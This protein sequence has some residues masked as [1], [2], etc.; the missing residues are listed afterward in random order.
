MKCLVFNGWA[1]GPET[2]ELCTFPH[3]YVF[4][5]L[6]QLDGVPEKVMED[7]DEVLLVGFSMGG[8]TALRMLLKYPEKVKG[9]VL[10]SAT[11]RMM[12]EREGVGGREQGVGGREQGVG[13]SEV[14]WK[15]MSLRRRA[16]L[17][18]GTQMAFRN[19][20]SPLYVEANLDR[21]LDYLQNTDLRADLLAVSSLLPNPY[22]LIPV[23]I[24][25]SERD[26]I[27]RSNNAE[28]LKGVFP[29]AKVTLVPGNEHVLPITVPE[30]IDKAVFDI[31]GRDEDEV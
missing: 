11:P 8:S 24:F 19:D 30:L 10:I 4:D 12:E 22:S 2:W 26:G 28:F 7:S 25:Q 13:G 3:D 15:G 5:Y 16:A 9:L 27:V 14:V 17:K 20:H 31:M 18:L 1:A 29:Q 6:E 23:H 21:G